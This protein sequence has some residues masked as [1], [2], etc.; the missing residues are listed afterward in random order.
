MN[1]D[2]MPE[3]KLLSVESPDEKVIIDFLDG[4]SKKKKDRRA[5]VVELSISNGKLYVMVKGC[6]DRATILCDEAYDLPAEDRRH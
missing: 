6:D 4:T 1:G 2:V 3:P 5:C